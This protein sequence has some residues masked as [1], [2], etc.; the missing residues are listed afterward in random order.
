MAQKK[1][2]VAITGA[3]GFVGR[4]LIEALG[5]RFHI[6]GLTRGIPG[7]AQ[8]KS[9]DNIEWRSCDLYSMLD[10]EEGLKG[11][12]YAFYLVH[13]MMPSAR[14]TPAKFEDLDLLLADNFARAAEKNGVKQI[15]FL[16]GIT[17]QTSELSAHLRSRLEV[18]LALGSR[19][20]PVTAIR[21]G[22]IVGPG[23]SSFTI[24]TQ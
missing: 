18:E 7:A 20:T 9:D 6:V 10:A 2:T 19:S 3:N 16:G 8:R 4:A 11:V 13:S 23:G 5:D 14:L 21:A 17:P 15:V 1:P 22:L 12:D 24:D